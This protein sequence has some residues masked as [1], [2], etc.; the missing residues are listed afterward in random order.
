MK[1]LRVYPVL[2]VLVFSSILFSACGPT[3]TDPQAIDSGPSG[4][5]Q[6]V[7]TA[8]CF[9]CGPQAVDSG[10][11]EVKPVVLTMTVPP[12]GICPPGYYYS[13]PIEFPQLAFCVLYPTPTPSPVPQA[14]NSGPPILNPGMEV[15]QYCA[16]KG[17]NLGGANISFPFESTLHVDDWNSEGPGQVACA[18]DLSNPRTCWGPESA[19]FEVLL[20]NGALGQ[21]NDN[22]CQKLPVTLGAC[23]QK[24]VGDDQPDAI[25]TSCGHC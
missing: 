2:S 5:K 25:P 4:S 23:A 9:N 8:P 6:E 1:T 7:P 20:C 15:V 18:D 16:N 10:P 12:D 13:G 17:A 21:N 3:N 22:Q 11:V 19:T 14:V 24:R